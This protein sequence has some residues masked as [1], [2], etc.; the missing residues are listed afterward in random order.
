MEIMDTSMVKRESPAA[1]R[2]FGRVKLNVQTREAMMEYRRRIS[3]QAEMASELRLN[4]VAR[5]GIKM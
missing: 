5:L 3:T 4:R 1:R 2:A